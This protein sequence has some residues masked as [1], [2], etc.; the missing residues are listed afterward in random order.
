MTT[1]VPREVSAQLAEMTRVQRRATL[2]R[3]GKS[4]SLVVGAVATGLFVVLML[5]LP[6]VVELHPYA[7]DPANRLQSPSAEHLMGTDNFGRDLLARVVHGARTSL[8]LGFTVA[9]LTTVFGV[10]IGLLAGYYRALDQVLMRV[11]D[12]LMAIPPI[13]LAIALMAALGPTVTNVILAMV[14][15]YTPAL[16]RVVRSRTLS[17]KEETYIEA[18]SAQGASEWRIIRRHIAP[19]VV[20]VVVVQATF[21]FADAIIT[22]AALSFLG[23]GVPPPEPSW[24]NILYDAKQYIFNAWWMTVFPALAAVVAV[25]ALNVLGDGLRDLVDPKSAATSRRWQRRYLQARAKERSTC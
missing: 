10:I 15:V 22:E 25:I 1:T 20:S 11:C 17:V 3:I 2:R 5:S 14:I 18:M 4:K 16:A 8:F 7:V 6:W 23:A 19:N 13:L 21:I 9:A 24:G 12:G